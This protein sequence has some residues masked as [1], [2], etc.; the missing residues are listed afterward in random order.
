METLR[1]ITNIYL[2]F[3]L[4][5]LS[6]RFTL[7]ANATLIK[8]KPLKLKLHHPDTVFYK[9]D[10][11]IED[12]ANRFLNASID[13]LSYL[14]EKAGGGDPEYDARGDLLALMDTAS[15][16][17]W[18][19]CKS[20]T[21]FDPSDSRTFAKYTCLDHVNVPCD[22]CSSANE[23]MFAIRY[24]TGGSSEGVLATE[25]FTFESSDEGIT[26]VND[27]VFGCSR[28]ISNTRNLMGVFGLATPRPGYSIVK[29]MGNKF[30]YCIGNL[31]D[32][33][34]K[35][36]QISLGEGTFLDGAATP[37]TNYRGI[38]TSMF[39][40]FSARMFCLAFG[41]SSQKGYDYFLVI[42]VLAQ[43]NHNIA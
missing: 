32:K 41:P 12:R 15:D 33:D 28:K 29:K 4:T 2:L 37:L 13:R 7:A 6:I 3:S 18:V 23:C 24:A 31:Y 35:Y 11:T 38:Y 43:Q 39:Y 34:Y 27:V 20:L 30:S 14:F 25:R 40:Q 5:F 9:P 42:G 1:A 10:D 21:A 19:D 17:I 36:N 8:P 26:I 22:T 16:L